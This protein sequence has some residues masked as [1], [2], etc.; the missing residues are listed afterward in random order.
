M[1]NQSERK[2]FVCGRRELSHRSISTVY[3]GYGRSQG[4][5]A[6]ALNILFETGGETR[7]MHANGLICSEDQPASHYHNPARSTSALLSRQK[8]PPPSRLRA[9]LALCHAHEE[10]DWYSKGVRDLAL[11][12]SFERFVG[13]APPPTSEVLGALCSQH[14]EW[15]FLRSARSSS[16]EWQYDPAARSAN[17]V[18]GA[19]RLLGNGPP[20]GRPDCIWHLLGAVPSPCSSCNIALSF[21]C[22]PP[23][24]S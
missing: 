13:V 4:V 16:W 18:M 8:R 15:A 22:H 24:P 11:E 5:V 2:G 19:A 6:V 20:C 14:L 12:I 9:S 21:A 3:T 1:A 10:K 17:D 23:S 7:P